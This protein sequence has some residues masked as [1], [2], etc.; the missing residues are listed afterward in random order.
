MN[1]KRTFLQ[2]LFNY[3]RPDNATSFAFINLHFIEPL[4]MAQTLC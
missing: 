4:E 2:D 3:I 1:S